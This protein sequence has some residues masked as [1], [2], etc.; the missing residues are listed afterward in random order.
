MQVTDFALCPDISPAEADRGPP[1]VALEA[2]R[3]AVDRAIERIRTARE[4]VMQEFAAQQGKPTHRYDVDQLVWVYAPKKSTSKGLR[5]PWIGP[6]RIVE[7][8]SPTIVQVHAP[9][10]R[11]HR[12]LVHVSRIKPF[13][14]ELPT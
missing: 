2:R 8:R 4:K 9:T 1:L 12:G 13:R 5:M 11:M 6:F 10:S 7:V 14:G 3:M